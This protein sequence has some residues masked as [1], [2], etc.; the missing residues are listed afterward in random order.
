M[1]GRAHRSD[2]DPISR[3]PKPLLEQGAGEVV[4]L[5]NRDVQ[6]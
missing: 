1:F 5:V 2:A 6:T 3:L 4:F